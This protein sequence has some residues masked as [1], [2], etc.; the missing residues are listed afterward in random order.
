M[1]SNPVQIPGAENGYLK[2]HAQLLISS[3]HRVTGNDLV[4]ASLFG[5]QACRFLFEAPF[6]VVSHN[7]EDD[8]VF[9]YGNQTALDLFEL[10]W[11][12][13]TRLASRHSAEPVNQEERKKLLERVSQQGFIDDYSGVRKSS[14]GR[15]FMIENATVWNLVDEQGTYRGQ[16]AV[17][18]NWKL[19]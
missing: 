16:A 18:H 12:E 6:G 4:P 5:Q 14:S 11:S 19:L 15:R 17:F 1:A 8:P 9:N 13:F 3:Y 7:T 2:H 10:D